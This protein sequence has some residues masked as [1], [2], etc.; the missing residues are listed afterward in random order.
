AESCME[1]ELAP[2]GDEIATV[3]AQATVAVDGEQ[4]PYRSAAVMVQNER[5]R[6]RRARIDAARRV[7]I[8]RL[9]PL[10][11]RLFRR[12]HELIGELGFPGYVEFYSTLKGIDVA[13]LG[14]R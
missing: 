9:N 11:E 10:R 7:E 1:R 5:D 12:H 4:V 14:Q 3:E 8:A 13:A 2:L 6:E